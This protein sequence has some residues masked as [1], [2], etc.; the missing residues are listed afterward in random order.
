[1]I[2]LP[3]RTSQQSVA[4]RP[5]ENLLHDS[6]FIGSTPV[7]STG[8]PEEI[9]YSVPSLI[10]ADCRTS[11]PAEMSMTAVDFSDSVP[12]ARSAKTP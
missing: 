7:N 4:F 1:M 6:A 8:L 5:N 12:Q 11:N 9:G 3:S 10:V 2:G